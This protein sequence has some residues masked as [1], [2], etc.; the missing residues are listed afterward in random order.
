MAPVLFK[1]NFF[2]IYTYGV[3]VAAGFLLSTILLLRETKKRALFNEDLIYNLCIILLA[4]GIVFARALYVILNWEYFSRDLREIFMI[5]HGGLVWFGGLVGAT[6]T[7]IIYLK[8]HRIKVVSVLDLFMPYVALG[9]AVGRI[10]CFFNGC[11]YGKQWPIGLYFPS[12]GCVLFPSQLVS[13]L[14]LLLIFFILMYKRQVLKPGSTFVFY[15]IL[16]SIQRFLM[17]FLRGDPRPFY[18]PFSVF[19][20]IS[21]GLFLV[22]VIAWYLL[23]WKR[24]NA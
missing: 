16:A 8:V 13:S 9:Q 15:L 22:G 7:G 1:C 21:I 3:F 2:T 20:W 6:I 4:S 19:Q 11:C 10:G 24:K 12:H 5:H 14:T 23:L 18:G 17:E